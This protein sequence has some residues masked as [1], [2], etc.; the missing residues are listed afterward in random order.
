MVY[1]HGPIN[2]ILGPLTRVAIADYQRDHGLYITSAI[3]EATLASL[4]MV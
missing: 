2:G 1:Y 3:D 4:E